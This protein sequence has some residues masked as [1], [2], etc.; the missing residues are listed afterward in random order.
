MKVLHVISGLDIGGAE[1]S[2]FNLISS[3]PADRFE[4]IVFSLHGE[5]FYAK[6]IRLL[7]ARVYVYDL[8]HLYKFLGEFRRLSNTF[9][10]LKPD[11]LQGWMNHGI[12][13][14]TLIRI[15][16]RKR[17]APQLI[18]SIRQSLD[19]IISLKTST[20]I[21]IWIN[22]FLASFSNA[23]IY[24]SSLSRRQHEQKGYLM[25]RGYVLPNGF[26]TNVFSSDLDERD[27]VRAKFGVDQ[28]TFLIGHV[29]RF[30]PMKDHLTFI[31]AAA[32][33]AQDFPKTYFMLVGK[34]VESNWRSISKELPKNL[35]H[36]FLILSERCDLVSL[37]RAMDSLCLSSTSESFP[38]VLGEA[39]AC[40]V[41][42]I[43]TEV[44]DAAII[45]ED[46]GFVVPIAD[47]EKLAKA[48]E[49][50]ISMPP[51]ERRNMGIKAR[52][53]IVAN[54]SLNE[55]AKAYMNLYD[56]LVELPANN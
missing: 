19:S 12:L 39:M 45:I 7:G 52:E 55:I 38:N 21:I 36:R 49:K 24:N 30:H 40:E 13:I 56:S 53:R 42:C 27:I 8:S 43:S 17:V 29:A 15:L 1:R 34:D 37:Y 47:F 2:L 20:K 50:L 51:I 18:W 48:L 25:N 9:V 31:K 4:H 16:N 54:Y 33:V 26:D 28:D 22:R 11:I 41:P 5:G 3:L 32:L 46:T 6:Q 14:S 44:G 10:I 35:L 23:I